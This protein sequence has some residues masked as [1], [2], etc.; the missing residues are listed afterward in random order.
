MNT[1]T[2]GELAWVFIFVGVSKN[3]SFFLTIL[4]NS[5]NFIS[6]LTRERMFSFLNNHEK[7][8]EAKVDEVR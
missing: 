6:I 2:R 7:T 4:Q 3:I 5:Y 1:K 8:R